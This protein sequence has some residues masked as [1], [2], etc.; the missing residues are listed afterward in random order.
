MVISTL[1]GCVFL[2]IFILDSAQD[3]FGLNQPDNLIEVTIPQGATTRQVGDILFDKG[4][5][6]KNLIFTL[7]AG[8]KPG[9]DELQP[10]NYVFNT[11]MGYDELISELRTGILKEEIVKLQFLEGVTVKEIADTLDKEG[12]CDADEFLDYLQTAELNYEFA[13]RMPTAPLRYRRMEGYM[14]P[15]TYEF[16][17]PERV[18]SVASKFFRNFSN[19]ISS[20]LQARMQDMGMSLDETITL[21]SIIQKEAGNPIDMRGVSS[22]FHNRLDSIELP[23]LESDV[24]IFYVENWIKPTIQNTNQ[25]MYD[26]YNTY[27]AEG[28]PAGPICNPGLA[29]IEA[30][31]YPI[32]SSNFFFVTDVNNEFYYSQTKA[33]HDERVAF[34]YAQ[35]P[36]DENAEGEV[37][38]T[39]I[40]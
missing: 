39:G 37:H 31:L 32:D 2:S 14:F 25:P 34:A 11:N 23:R 1:V 38:G 27:V 21:A 9:G 40:Q 29:A 20:D 5:I 17:V 28:L 4:V 10:G 8:L 22:V 13:D 16:Y 35:P 19:R 3:L 12:V 30:A 24:T 26:A 33:E 18:D 36:A 7:Y 15:D 6:T